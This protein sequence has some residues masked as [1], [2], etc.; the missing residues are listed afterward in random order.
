VRDYGLIRENV[1]SHLDSLMTKKIT[2]GVTG[3]SRAGKTV[4]I[5]SLAQALLTSDSWVVRRGQ[6]PLAQFGAFE[7][8]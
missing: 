7:R 6:G 4:F 3:F 8:G 2:L 5:G 1:Q